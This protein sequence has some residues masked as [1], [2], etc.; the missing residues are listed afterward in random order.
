MSHEQR[1][2]GRLATWRTNRQRNRHR[3]AMYKLF[4]TVDLDSDEKTAQ[5]H[6][7]GGEELAAEDR[8]FRRK[9]GG[10]GGGLA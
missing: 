5:R 6:T 2:P 3:T 10:A 1:K 8:R 9:A 7:T 4:G